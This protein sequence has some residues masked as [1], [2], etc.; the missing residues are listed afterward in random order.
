MDH[1]LDSDLP[2][3]TYRHVVPFPVALR[4]I[5]GTMAAFIVLISIWELWRGVWP[6]NITSPFFGIILFTAIA[7]GTRLGFAS[8]LG[9]STSWHVQPGRI[10]FT[11]LAPFGSRI[12]SIT[13]GMVA[14]I[15]CLEHE[16]DGDPNN[17]SVTLRTNSGQRYETRRFETRPAAEAMRQR[18]EAIFLQ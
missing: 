16:R 15:T 14:E 5:L 18:I 10:D 17:W 13:P 3:G 7:V 4:F 9:P 2:D 6:L 12:T 8:I 11:Q 1:P